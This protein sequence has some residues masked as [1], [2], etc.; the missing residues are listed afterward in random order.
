MVITSVVAA[1]KVNCTPIWY[2]PVSETVRGL[3]RFVVGF[4]SI[5]VSPA[6]TTIIS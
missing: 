4:A 3:P 6:F 1:V 2:V 5:V